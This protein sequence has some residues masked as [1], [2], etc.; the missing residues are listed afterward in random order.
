[1]VDILSINPNI[2]VLIEKTCFYSSEDASSIEKSIIYSK[3]ILVGQIE[4]FNPIVKKIKNIIDPEDIIQI[5]TSRVGNVPSREKIDCRKD[6]GIHDLDFSIFVKENFP[7]DLFIQSNK[8][9]THEVMIY[10]IGETLV[11]NEV[12]WCYPFKER[13]FNILTKNGIYKGNFFHQTLD[14][15]DWTGQK[16]SIPIDKK[17]PLINEINYFIDMIKNKKS[18]LCNLKENLSLVKL[19]GY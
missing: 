3:S 9:S 19:L 13:S 14:F 12:S 18:S 1:M 5:K 17:E 2:K 6:L 16:I 15:I 4:R 7:K 10:S 11:Q 8:N